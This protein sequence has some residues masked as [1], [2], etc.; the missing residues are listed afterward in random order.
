VIENHGR[1][2]ALRRVV[3]C[4]AGIRGVGG[5]R[6]RQASRA[7]VS[8]F[9]IMRQLH[10]LLWYRGEAQALAAPDS[11]RAELDRAIERTEHL[12]GDEP[13][14]QLAIDVVAHR[15]EV[16]AIPVRASETVRAAVQHRP[17]D[18]HQAGPLAGLR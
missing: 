4:G 15:H 12:A 13:H 1:L 10:E 18:L 11:R 17:A 6:D 5:F 8:E 16:N 9:P 14:A 7:A 2:R 3:L